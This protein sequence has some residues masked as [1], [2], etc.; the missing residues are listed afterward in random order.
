MSRLVLYSSLLSANGRKVEAVCHALGITPSIFDTNVYAGKGQ[1][2]SYLCLNPLGQIPVLVDQEQVIK[3]SNAIVVYLSEQYRQSALYAD[4]AAQRAKINSWLFW[5]S[6]QWQPSLIAAM[7]S[8]VGHRLLPDILP[9]PTDKANWQDEILVKQLDFLESSLV[10]KSWL[11]D[12][13]ISLADYAVAAM[14][15]YFH[16]AEFPFDN[17][18]NITA[19]YKRLSSTEAWKNTEVPLWRSEI[20][21]FVP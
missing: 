5:E 6:S 9:E 18:P 11:V 7:S 10:Q 3:E 19:W 12:D 16:V 13:Q 21:N 8:Q 4:T 1:E 17:Y 15:T 2:G 20:V 14:T